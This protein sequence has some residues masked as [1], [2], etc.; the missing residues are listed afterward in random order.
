MTVRD[1]KVPK[2]TSKEAW[3]YIQQI[4]DLIALLRGRGRN[5]KDAAI[6]FCL[7]MRL[8]RDTR[9]FLQ[10]IFRKIK[11]KIKAEKE[12]LKQQYKADEE[13]F[14]RIIAIIEMAEQA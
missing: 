9:T 2:G 4:K 7:K 10:G 8:D 14:E 12:L 6:T 5:P 3:H 13:R 11:A 1:Q